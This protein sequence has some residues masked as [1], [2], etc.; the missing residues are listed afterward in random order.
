MLGGDE[1]AVDLAP[2]SHAFAEPVLMH[3]SRARL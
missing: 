3:Q 2:A 1:V